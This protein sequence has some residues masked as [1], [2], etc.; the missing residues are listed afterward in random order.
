V[1][2]KVPRRAQVAERPA[3]VCE[4]VDRSVDGVAA[5]G[6]HIRSEGVGAL[7]DVA[8]VTSCGP[9]GDVQV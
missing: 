2:A 9:A 3:G 7:D 8:D 4:A 5:E 6:D 1:T